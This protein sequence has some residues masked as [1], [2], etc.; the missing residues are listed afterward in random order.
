MGVRDVAPI[1]LLVFLTAFLPAQEAGSDNPRERA[2]AA[3]A[4]AEQGSSAIPALRE[5]LR[6][7]EYEVR[8]E[9]VKAIVQIGTQH[10]LDA[11]IDATR[12][13][14]P[15]IQI[16]ATD[17]L[18]DFYLPGYVKTGLTA[19]LR[20]V[21]KSIKAK[22]TD[23]NDQVVP[24]H[25]QVR[26]EVIEAL[27]KLASGGSS[28]ESRANAARA[29]GVL[30]GRAAVPHLLEAIRSKNTQVIYE[31]LIA[32]QKIQEP[33]AA[34]D[35]AFLLRDLD[36]RV[37]V[38]ALETTGLLG[39]KD[40]LPQL[41]DALK[42]ARN[43]RVRRAALTAI[44]MLPDESSRP[45]YNQYINHKDDLTRAAAAEGF[46][47]LRNPADL[48]LLERAF[49]AE[50]KMNPRLSLAF[51]LVLHGKTEL[52]EFSPLQYLVNTLNS[53]SYHGVA[54]P[55]LVETARDPTVRQNLYSALRYGT[56]LEK[57]RLAQVLARSGDAE[58][59]PHL[60][61]LTKDPDPEVATEAAGALRTLKQRL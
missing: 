57:L 17:G 52:K 29:V 46:G 2:R 31:S 40:A 3:R 35:I 28:M 49:E 24:L 42:N 10:S 50:T 8:L 25:M 34:K 48:P 45:H 38:A 61:E 53:S 18:V 27:G 22:F 15:E 7:P 44:A 13:A 39:N 14:D 47:R 60:E 19:T 37:Q 23:V 21:G 58:S 43:A 33:S 9:A 4:M 41:Y 56:R 12:D 30:R 59:V 6:D 20:K 5:M 51:A 16:R 54:L 32:L 1:I 55:F 36:D 11:L 26:P